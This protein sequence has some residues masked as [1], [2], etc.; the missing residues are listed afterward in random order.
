[1]RKSAVLSHQIEGIK[2]RVSSLGN[3]LTVKFREAL[4]V[5]NTLKKK[6]V[7]GL[8]PLPTYLFLGTE[9]AKQFKGTKV[10]GAEQA[11]PQQ[12]QAQKRPATS[13]QQQRSGIVKRPISQPPQKTIKQ[14]V[15]PP[16]QPPQQH[17]LIKLPTPDDS[18][19]LYR[20]PW[21]EYKFK[22]NAFYITLHNELVVELELIVREM[23][24]VALDV[25]N[26]Q[27]KLTQAELHMSRNS[28]LAFPQVLQFKRQWHESNDLYDFLDG[29]RLLIL[30]Q[31]IQMQQVYLRK[32]TDPTAQSASIAAQP[33]INPPVSA[34]D[35]QLL[36]QQREAI[37]KATEE[38]ERLV[39]SQAVEEKRLNQAQ[40]LLQQLQSAKRR[41]KPAAV[42]TISNKIANIQ[43][44]INESEAHYKAI[45][46][47]LNYSLQKV[48]DKLV[49]MNALTQQLKLERSRRKLDTSR[50]PR[51]QS[52]ARH[53]NRSVITDE[54]GVKVRVIDL[55]NRQRKLME[56]IA[57][58][59]ERIKDFRQQMNETDNSTQVS[60]GFIEEEI[61]SELDIVKEDNETLE[62]IDKE[63]MRFCDVVIFNAFNYSQ[64]LVKHMRNVY[65]GLARRGYKPTRLPTRRPSKK[66]L[67]SPRKMLIACEL[68]KIK[69]CI[70]FI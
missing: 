9:N 5:Y 58:S 61:K 53:I 18:E 19:L 56:N 39:K 34:E 59:E 13:A 46:M 70:F 1:M 28:S 23:K 43:T 24:A 10:I 55:E 32:F 42:Q 11:K 6:G 65:K 68:R 31:M 57:A 35:R 7:L 17:Y 44:E 54:E 33:T 3:A 16:V 50:I 49:N 15:N 14:R 64:G 40:D 29:K 4:E 69:M 25:K 66:V 12:R 41:S 26:I 36:Q 48:R 2:E 45:E 51:R 8:K 47:N 27:E 21:M 63:L 37:L 52:M 38:T 67:S 20:V 62:I 30:S 22:G 60:F